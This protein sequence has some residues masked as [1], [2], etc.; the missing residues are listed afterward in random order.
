VT[1]AFIAIGEAIKNRLLEAPQMAGDRV[2][3]GRVRAGLRDWANM[4]VVRLVRAPA[5]LAGVG[6]GAPKDWNT[7]YAVEITARADGLALAEDVLDPILE[8][9]YARL[10]GWA[11]PGLS[12]LDAMSEPVISWDTEEAEDQLCRATLLITVTHRTTAQALTAWGG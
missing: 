10:A 6:M 2:F 8:A 11:P 9:A 3:R 12:V 7:T 1:S 5:E 4:I